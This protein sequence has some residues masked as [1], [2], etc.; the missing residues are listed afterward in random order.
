M[1]ET[2][3]EVGGG[4]EAVALTSRMET[5]CLR[6]RNFNKTPG[7]ASVTSLVTS[8]S[9]LS[10]RY[11]SRRSGLLA[12]RPDDVSMTRYDLSLP[13]E[14]SCRRRLLLLLRGEPS[15][16]LVDKMSDNL[17]RRKKGILTE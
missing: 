4:G 6:T 3:N 17:K 7:K 5:S 11:K 1:F 13:C 12:D 2:E 9:N 14:R 16:R 15:H 10:I 8:T